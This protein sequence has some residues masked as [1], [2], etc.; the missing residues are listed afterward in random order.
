MAAASVD[1]VLKQEYASDLPVWVD[2]D[3]LRIQQV[4]LNLLSN[5]LKFTEQGRI[6][7]KVFQDAGNTCFLVEDSGVGMDRQQVEALFTP[8]EQGDAST[9]RRF[10]GTGLGLAIS[11]DL[12]IRRCWPR[13]YCAGIRGPGSIEKPRQT[14]VSGAVLRNLG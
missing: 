10:G 3:F 13:R 4:L 7:L 8:F 2:G 14:R 1:L 11:R 5:A 9:T 6:G 12:S